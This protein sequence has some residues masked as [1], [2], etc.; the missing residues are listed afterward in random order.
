[1]RPNYK[2]GLEGFDNWIKAL[3]TGTA[4]KMGMAYNA[5]CWAECR[6]FGVQFLKEAKER[7]NGKTGTLFDE[8]AGHYEAVHENLQ[9]VAELFP[10]PLNRSTDNV[11]DS[12][13]VQTTI[14][15]LSDARK[16]EEA[17]LNSLEQIVKEL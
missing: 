10:F 14:K 5:A 13:L 17:G 9:K 1:M 4:V 3:E 7:I 11:T 16:A 6:G 8:A 12:E 2:A 15:H